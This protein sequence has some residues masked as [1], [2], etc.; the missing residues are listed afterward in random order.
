MRNTSHKSTD[1]TRALIARMFIH[2][3][4]FCA[5]N[6]FSNRFNFKR[7]RWAERE[8]KNK[9]PYNYRSSYLPLPRSIFHAQRKSI[10]GE[11]T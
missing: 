9:H 3:F 7:T 10:L 1:I 8:Y 5:T 2:V 6:F 11:R 4:A